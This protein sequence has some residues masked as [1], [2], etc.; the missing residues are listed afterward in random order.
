MF[1]TTSNCFF[2]FFFLTVQMRTCLVLPKRIFP[3][4]KSLLRFPTSWPQQRSLV[5][6]Q[7]GQ[8][9]RKITCTAHSSPVEGALRQ[10]H[11]GMCSDPFDWWD[12]HWG[13]PFLT[14]TSWTC[15]RV[16]MDLYEVIFFSCAYIISTHLWCNSHIMPREGINVSIK[17]LNP[18]LSVFLSLLSCQWIILCHL[19]IYL[20]SIYDMES[21][22]SKEKTQKHVTC[23]AVWKL[24]HWS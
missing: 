4:L 19:H 21:E 12:G 11:T 13:E 18:L 2:S 22:T 1:S 5:L 8:C 16:V 14:W 6:A 23:I 7:P 15:W 9:C 20:W 24:S 10:T 17:N 3:P